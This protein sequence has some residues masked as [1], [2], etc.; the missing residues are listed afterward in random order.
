MNENG[1][2]I[3]IWPV[4]AVAGK[5]PMV[6]EELLREVW[7]QMVQEN[8]AFTVFYDGHIRTEDDW[9]RFV[10]DSG[11]VVILLVETDTPRVAAVAWLNSPGPNFAFGHF[12]V[13]GKTLPGLGEKVLNFW[14]NLRNPASIR[15]YDMILGLIPESNQKAQEYVAALGFELVG[16]IPK[17]CTMAYHDRVEAGVLWHVDLEEHE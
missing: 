4:V 8:K 2:K 10:Y 13:L 11:N 3:S 9:I 15:Y 12:C 1:D 6:P 14:A 5:I 7:R 16:R 17:V